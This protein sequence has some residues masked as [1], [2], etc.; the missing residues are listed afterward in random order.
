MKT[1]LI[2]NENTSLIEYSAFFGSIQIFQYLMTNNA[3]LK[4]SLWLYA[5]HSQNAEIIMLLESNKVDFPMYNEDEKCKCIQ[6]Y[7][8]SIKC[9][10]N[11]IASYIENNLMGPNETDLKEEIISKC[12]EYHNY[13]HFQ[14]EN[15]NDY[16]FISLCF[17]NYKK[18]FDLLLKNKE[19]EIKAKI[20]ISLLTNQIQFKINQFFL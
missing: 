11:D 4:P 12:I 13:D 8:E 17:Y 7:L 1:F 18:L 15:I 9:H 5:I 3:E 14:I 10:H 19:E 20:K 6:C 2:D 16:G